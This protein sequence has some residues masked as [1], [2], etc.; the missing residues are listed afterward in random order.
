MKRP[1]RRKSAEHRH[2]AYT[3]LAGVKNWHGAA[4]DSWSSHLAV[5]VPEKGSNERLEPADNEQYGEL[6]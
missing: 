3:A 6:K 4:P 2:D 1:H 5:E